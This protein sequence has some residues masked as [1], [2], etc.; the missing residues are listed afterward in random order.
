MSAEQRETRKRVSSL[1]DAWVRSGM[2]SDVWP[3]SCPVVSNPTESQEEVADLRTGID[4]KSSN[5]DT[6]YPLIDL[7]PSAVQGSLAL[8]QIEMRI[9]DLFFTC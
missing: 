5:L 9:S 1:L 2:S 3:S 8:S 4:V 6:R 7:S